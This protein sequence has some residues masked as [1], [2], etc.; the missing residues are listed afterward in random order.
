MADCPVQPAEINGVTN[1]N[2]GQPFPNNQLPINPNDPTIAALEAM[3]P[4][5]HRRRSGSG[6]L[7]GI[8]DLAD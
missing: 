3:I 2:A 4:S 6:D 1:P 7:A 8:S 5:S